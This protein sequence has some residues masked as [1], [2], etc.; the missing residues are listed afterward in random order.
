MRLSDNLVY[1]QM[2]GIFGWAGTPAAFQ[3][4]TRAV[5][6]EMA[7]L[8]NGRATMYVDDVI[9]V[10]LDTDVEQDLKTTR[11]VCTDLLSP[12]A[13]ADD[14]TESGQRLDVLGYVVDLDI[15]R[16]L[17]ARRNSL[18]ALHGFLSVDLDG[19]MTLRAAQRLAS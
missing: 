16:V 11:G 8:L 3:V 1:L 13:V 7:N 9:G 5:E 18:T 12:E 15:R 17:I 10:S 4:I 19:S 6:W 2:V 14:K